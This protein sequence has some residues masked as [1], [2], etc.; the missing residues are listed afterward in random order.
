MKYI[1]YLMTLIAAASTLVA[2]ETDVDQPKL[3]AE[4]NYVAPVLNQQADII[5]NG[6]NVKVESVTFTCTPADFGLN[7]PVRYQLHLTKDGADIVAVT[8]YQPTMTMLKSDINGFV[9]NQLGVTANEAATIGAY[10]VAYAGESDICTPR[11]NAISFTV[12]TFKAALRN[13][14]ICGEFVGNWDINSAVEIW[15]TTGGSNVYEGLY[16]FTDTTDPADG[17]SGFKVMPNRAWDGGEKG[18]DA[19]TNDGKFSSSSDGNLQLPVGIWQVTIDLAN[20]TIAAKQFTQVDIM[21]SFDGWASPMLMNYDYVSNCWVSAS[22]V[23]GGDEYKIRMNGSWDVSYGGGVNASESLPDG[24][25]IE[26]GDNIKVPGSGSFY[27]ELHADRTPWVV[28]YKAA[29]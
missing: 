14:Y 3:D 19:F 1:K 4:E 24:F 15:E 5:V 27:V 10:V 11:S 9:V 2:C 20:M 6:D 29:Q 21:G 28:T 23:S 7:I 18:F 25:E 17:Q 22:T 13:Y 16:Q 8:A 12:Q 26:G